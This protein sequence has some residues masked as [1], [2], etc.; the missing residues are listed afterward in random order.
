[1]LLDNGAVVK[2]VKLGSMPSC[3]RCCK[4][5]KRCE[6]TKLGDTTGDIQ[7]FISNWDPHNN[8]SNVS[9]ACSMQLYEYCE[10]E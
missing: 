7:D 9:P 5:Y 10:Y 4:T 2:L 6:M 1:M 8:Y 3:W